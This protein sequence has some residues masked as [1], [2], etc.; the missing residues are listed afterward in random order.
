MKGPIL[1]L[2]LYWSSEKSLSL[3]GIN[4]H[5]NMCLL[6]KFSQS[7]AYSSKENQTGEL[8]FCYWLADGS[9]TGCD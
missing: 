5:F 4:I 6:L 2:N 7:V 3:S 8:D 9:T 1:Y